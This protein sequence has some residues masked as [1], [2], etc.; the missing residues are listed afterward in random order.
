MIITLLQTMR[1]VI[2]DRNPEVIEDMLELRFENAPD[3]AVAII[4]SKAGKYYRPITDGVSTINIK[5]IDGLVMVEVITPDGTSTPSRWRCENMV[6]IRLPDASVWLAPDD[7][8]ASSWVAKCFI[9]LEEANRRI[10]VLEERLEK[11]QKKVEGLY[12]AYDL[13]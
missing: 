7:S 3:G 13:V 4:D 8:E 9:E 12:E 5:A 11:L 6:A 10:K 2:T 1:G